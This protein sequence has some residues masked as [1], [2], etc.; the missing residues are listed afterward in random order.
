[1]DKIVQRYR[2]QKDIKTK[3][4]IMKATSK[5][6][7]YMKKSDDQKPA[8]FLELIETYCNQ[9]I[10]VEGC[11][12]NTE[13]SYKDCYALLF[14][15]I[16][17][18]MCITHDKITFSMLTNT[19]LTGFLDWLENERK[20]SVLTRNQRRAALC[21]FAKYASK[22]NYRAAG[23]FYTEMNKVPKK[24]G[25]GKKK[26]FF[27]LKELQI[28]LSLPQLHTLVGRRDS[29]LLITMYFTGAR[30]QEI[31]DL[32]VKDI[33]FLS[34]GFGRVTIH[35]KGDK[36]R[37]LPIPAAVAQKLKDYLSYQGI[38]KSNETHVF[39]SQTH[40]QMSISCVEEIYKKYVESAKRENPDLFHNDSYTPH[41][42]RH[43]TAVHMLEAGI[44][45]PKIQRFLGH[46]S[47]A[48]TQI[49]AEITQANLDRTMREWNEKTWGHINDYDEEDTKSDTA[50]KKSTTRR[51]DFLR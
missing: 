14:I 3:I 50:A 47:I 40:S 32:R 12:P 48:T 17:D 49:Y 19:I 4:S 27:T 38:S 35:G 22:M 24:R 41:S 20:C 39:S 15:Y 37:I 29:V 2:Y 13:K 45:L 21:A 7:T 51:P 36:R 31:C 23:C 8:V 18:T 5:E 46:A 26:S 16:E 30:A 43:T 25:S 42:M 33:E 6:A 11:S 1:M 10:L 28:I 9:L 44:P 34:S